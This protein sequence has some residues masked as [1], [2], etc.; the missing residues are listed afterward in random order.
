MGGGFNRYFSIK[1]VG[2]IGVSREDHIAISC[3]TLIGGFNRCV[4]YRDG[5]FNT[6]MCIEIVGLIHTT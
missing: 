6:N 3:Q 2:L 4:S 5:G 1:E